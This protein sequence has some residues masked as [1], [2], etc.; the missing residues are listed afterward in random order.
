MSIDN[1][2][3]PVAALAPTPDFLQGQIEK[4]TEQ[5]AALSTQVTNGQKKS[6]HRYNCGQTGYIQHDCF[7]QDQRQSN[8]RCFLCNQ[9]GH[10]AK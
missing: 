9:P 8:I 6:K 7:Y 4:L 5:V 1:K 2:S 3:L 10:I